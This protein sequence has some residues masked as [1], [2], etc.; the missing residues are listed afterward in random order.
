MTDSPYEFTADDVQAM[1]AADPPSATAGELAS[2]ARAQTA[3]TIRVPSPETA[4]GVTYGIDLYENNAWFHDA[5]TAF[6]ILKAY[7]PGYG[8]DSKFAARFPLAQRLG[9]LR[10]AYMFGHPAQNAAAAVKAFTGILKDNGFTR[11]DR[12][13][14]DHEMTD[15]K[16][17]SYCAGWARDVC[18]GID[19]ELGFPA[20]GV[21]T[22]QAFIEV[23]NCAGLGQY[24]L[25]LARYFTPSAPMPPVRIGG[26]PWASCVLDQYGVFTVDWDYYGGPLTALRA[27]WDQ[28]P[29]PAPAGA[30]DAPRGLRVDRIGHTN[31]VAHWLPPAGENPET[32]RVYVYHDVNGHLAIVPSY[33]PPRTVHTTGTG[34][35]GMG[36]LQRHQK[37]VLRVVSAGP[38]GRSKVKPATYAQATFTT[39]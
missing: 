18:A 14:L 23:G 37:Y 16:S 4:A 39:G 29:P 21:Y 26:S 13:F 5:T 36:G 8:R 10:G 25:W 7:E 33:H 3:D 6:V 34:D 2:P 19:S 31:F 17:P 20:C 30:Y 12:A 32:Y 22:Y 38:D 28:T 9:M 15:G 35:A 27:W 24:P 11:A 1:Q